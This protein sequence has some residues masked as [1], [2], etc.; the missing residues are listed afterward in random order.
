MVKSLSQVEL[1]TV[2]VEMIGFES[3]KDRVLLSKC[4]VSLHGLCVST[5]CATAS[6]EVMCS[7][8]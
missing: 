5:C 1:N 6:S 8:I 2:C 3:R 4:N 7:V